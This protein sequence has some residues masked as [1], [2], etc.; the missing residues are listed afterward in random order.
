MFAINK[1]VV[2]IVLMNTLTT[3]NT[4]FTNKYIKEN[5]MDMDKSKWNSEITNRHQHIMKTGKSLERV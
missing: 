1:G 2:Q 4:L 5:N 3:P